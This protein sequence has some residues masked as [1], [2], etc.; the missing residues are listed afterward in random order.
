[1]DEEEI[2]KLA[3]ATLSQAKR[4]IANPADISRTKSAAKAPTVAAAVQLHRRLVTGDLL[5]HAHLAAD[6]N[7]VL[8]Q[9][10]KVKKGDVRAGYSHFL[11]FHA[12]TI[13]TCLVTD[14]PI[15]IAKDNGIL[16][17]GASLLEANK[18]A[19]K[20]TLGKGWF[21]LEV[22]YTAL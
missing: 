11:V 18:S 9:S 7:G 22:R 5:Q 6:R 8:Q 2:E 17:P 4:R 12:S 20:K 1:M 10:D 13:M 19:K 14:N 15:E 21:D 3:S 16:D